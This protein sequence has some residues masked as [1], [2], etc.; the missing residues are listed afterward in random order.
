MVEGVCGSITRDRIGP[1]PGPWL[2]QILTSAPAFWR[3]IAKKT[4]LMTNIKTI[5]M[6]RRDVMAATHDRKLGIIFES[7]A[8]LSYQ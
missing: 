1:P 6:N 5:W 2:V 3:P 7:L 4:K 8:E